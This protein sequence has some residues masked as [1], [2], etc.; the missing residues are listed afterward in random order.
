MFAATFLITGAPAPDITI[1]PAWITIYSLSGTTLEI[2]GTPPGGTTSFNLSVTA[3]NGVDPAASYGPAAVTVVPGD[4]PPSFT[5]PATSPIAADAT[6]GQAF[7]LPI[8]VSGYP[9]PT[10]THDALPAWL[11][12]SASA[13]WHLSGT[14]TGGATSFDA[15]LHASNGVGVA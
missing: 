10:V 15:T 4:T 7:D 9:T 12:L 8:S 14:P 6:V 3:D 1:S 11:S 13:P 5:S 2:R